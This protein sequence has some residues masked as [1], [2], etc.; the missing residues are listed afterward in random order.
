MK[1]SLPS[2]YKL[3]LLYLVLFG[4]TVVVA[5][6][7]YVSTDNTYIEYPKQLKDTVLMNT[8]HFYL[9]VETGLGFN[10]GPTVTTTAGDRLETNA[11]PFNAY[12]FSMMSPSKFNIGYAYKN[13]H[14]EGS[15]GMLREKLNISI[16]DD[17]GNRAIDYHRAQTYGSFTLR[18]FYRFPY[19]IPRLKLMMGAEIGGAFRPDNP[20][21]EKGY[22]VYRDTGYTF[23]T[24]IREFH[25]FQ[26]VLGVSTRMDIKLCKNLSL[27]LLATV[28]GSPLR[29]TEYT[30]VYSVPG[31]TNQTAQVYSTL[32]NVNLN[33]GLK[34]ELFSHKKKR[35]T[36]DRYG[37]Q[38][39]FRD[40]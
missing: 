18:Y 4:I 15:F 33:A 27:T 1:H 6:S 21:Q 26:L 22:T 37:I 16:M 10:V 19:Q 2:L 28:L 30:F 23:N 40:K 35:E 39:P 34:L 14:F 5:H 7:Q 36:Y 31:G 17:A 20:M 29:G 3:I 12:D 9:T 32:I 11:A 8:D 38:D 25:D 13:H 24:Y